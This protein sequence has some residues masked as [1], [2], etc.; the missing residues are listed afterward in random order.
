MSTRMVIGGRPVF[1]SRDF[2]PA[3]SAR[4][5]KMDENKILPIAPHAQPVREIGRPY[6]DD[7]DDLF[8]RVVEYLDPRDSWMLAEQ[9]MK[10][11]A[12]GYGTVLK[13]ARM[14]AIEPAMEFG[15]PTKRYRVKDDAALRKVV[16]GMKAELQTIKKRAPRKVNRQ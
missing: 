1:A 13:L 11:Y 4:V 8:Y 10:R 12:V 5:E 7:E 16:S 3:Q 6:F 15:S 2:K 9:I 14:G